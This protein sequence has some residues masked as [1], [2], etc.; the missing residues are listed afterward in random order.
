MF[1]TKKKKKEIAKDIAFVSSA[2]TEIATE[3]RLFAKCQDKLTEIADKIGGINMVTD[4]AI[5]VHKLQTEIR[6]F[7]EFEKKINTQ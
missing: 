1:L 4:V 3:C 7:E 6:A 2:L 5:I